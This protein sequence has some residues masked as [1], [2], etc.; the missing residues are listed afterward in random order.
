MQ[1]CF[2]LQSKVKILKIISSRYLLRQIF[3]KLK[4]PCNFYCLKKEFNLAKKSNY[5]KYD[6]WTKVLQK[7]Y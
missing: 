4:I 5:F 3:Q 7:K 6:V 2:N 1:Q